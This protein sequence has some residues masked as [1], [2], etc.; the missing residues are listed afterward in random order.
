RGY[1]YS[2]D[3]YNPFSEEEISAQNSINKEC[4]DIQDFANLEDINKFQIEKYYFICPA[5]GGDKS[6]KLIAKALAKTNKVAIGTWAVRSKEHLV[7]I[8][9]FEDGLILAVL[10]YSDEVRTFESSCANHEF[11]DHEIDLAV[12]LINQFT[13]KDFDISKHYN[14]FN[15]NMHA[16]VE[17][18]LNNKE[19]VQT[20]AQPI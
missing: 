10:Y 2:K 4:I 18:K 19:T 15:K 12:Q 7:M 13:K 8:T 1:E 6:Y 16:L 3:K 5:K 17:Q 20:A 11:E 14:K 9:P